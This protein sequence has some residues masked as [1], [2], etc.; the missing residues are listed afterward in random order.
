MPLPD[1]EDGVLDDL[2]VSIL[3]ELCKLRIEVAKSNRF[4]HCRSAPLE[5]WCNEIPRIVDGKAD[6]LV[7]FG[8]VR[9]R[10]AGRVALDK[11]PCGLLVGDARQADEVQ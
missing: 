11:S 4:F 3:R 8:I 7:K 1:L 10:A 6:Q 9:G 5:L 2:T